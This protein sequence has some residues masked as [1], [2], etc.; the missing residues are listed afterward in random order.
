MK[1]FQNK[2]L[3]ILFP[4]HLL[5]LL[6]VTPALAQDKTPPPVVD[7]DW[8]QQNLASPDLRIIDLA[9][10][11]KNYNEGH[12]PG[13]VFIDWRHEIIDAAHTELYLMPPQ[14]QFEELMT[15]LAVTHDTQFVLTDNLETRGSIRFY[16]T[17]R[18]Y[19]HDKVCIL[20]GGTNAWKAAGGLL[21]TDVPELEPV[22]YKAAKVR[23]EFLTSIAT[24]Q[25]AIDDEKALILDGRSREQFTGEAPGKIFHTGKE[26][27]RRG[28]ITSAVNIPWMQNFNED[29]T[30]KTVEQ[31]KELYTGNGVADDDHI[32]TYCNEGLHAT[33][34][35][36]VLHELLGHEKTKVY[37]HS[38]GEWA[39][40]DETPMTEGDK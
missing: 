29:G 13:A 40:Q 7:V 12:I 5:V 18:Y 26:H 20:N 11:Q 33:V 27:K 28:H 4:A 22:A 25:E 23:P 38:L 36:F 24:V 39:N 31:L 8:L 6:L 30:F 3:L 37:E 17:L 15:R 34:P 1:Y 10:R 21:T 2:S 14:E 16:L 32:V 35:W 19:G 9:H